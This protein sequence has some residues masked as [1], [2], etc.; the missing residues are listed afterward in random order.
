MNDVV[1][2]PA[3]LSKAASG[4]RGW[5]GTG[6]AAEFVERLAATAP[7]DL[8]YDRIYLT[9]CQVAA[10]RLADPV[11][12]EYWPDVEEVLV[13]AARQIYDPPDDVPDLKVVR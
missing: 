11:C 10:E 7:I 13:R 12:S 4:F 6:K 1:M 3:L 9:V 2:M 5:R 8:A